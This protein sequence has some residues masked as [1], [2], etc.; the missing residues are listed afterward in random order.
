LPQENKWNWTAFSITPV[1][2]KSWQGIPDILE[3]I[4]RGSIVP[5]NCLT[6]KIRPS[7]N[8]LAS[9]KLG[10]K[11]KKFLLFSAPL[12]FEILAETNTGE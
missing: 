7:Y 8:G 6:P 12:I 1:C 10:P 11:K 2:R 9:R 3:A 5:R 4:K